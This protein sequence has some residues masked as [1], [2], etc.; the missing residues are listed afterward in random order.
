MSFLMSIFF[1]R[2]TLVFAIVILPSHD[3]RFLRRVLSELDWMI[4]LDERRRFML[5]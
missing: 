5:S 3:P 4:S 1:L 2:S